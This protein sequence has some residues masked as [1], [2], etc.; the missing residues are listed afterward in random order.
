VTACYNKCTK[1]QFIHLLTATCNEW[2]IENSKNHKKVISLTI[3]S[4]NCQC[5]VVWLRALGN[6][7]QCRPMGRKALEELYVFLNLLHA[8]FC[9]FF[10]ILQVFTLFSQLT[11]ITFDRVNKK[12]WT[13]QTIS[14]WEVFLLAWRPVFRPTR[15]ICVQH[16]HISHYQ[17]MTHDN[18]NKTK[19]QNCC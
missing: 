12:L 18:H 16:T 2:H 8:L 1:H 19:S 13:D 3:T 17:Q 7:D 15:S 10:H 6:E 11:N 5:A 14:T 9:H 4:P